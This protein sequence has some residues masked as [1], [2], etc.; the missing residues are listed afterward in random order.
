VINRIFL[1]LIVLI[2][3]NNGL[4][5]FIAKINDISLGQEFNT[6]FTLPRIKFKNNDEKQITIRNKVAKPILVLYVKQ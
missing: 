6:G 4:I 2:F 1:N 3:I 5:I